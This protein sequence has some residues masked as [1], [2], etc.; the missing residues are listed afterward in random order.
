MKGIP[1]TFRKWLAGFFDGEGCV[2][3]GGQKSSCFRVRIDIAQKKP[4][5]LYHIQRI[6]GVGCVYRTEK[7]IHHLRIIGGKE[8]EIAFIK[9]ILPFSLVKQE[10]LKLA[11]QFLDL[12]GVN[13]PRIGIPKENRRRRITLAKE[14]TAFKYKDYTPRQGDKVSP[15]YICGFW[16]GDGSIHPQGKTSSYRPRISIVQKF[17]NI[18]YM[19]QKHLGFGR[20]RKP[21]CSHT[22]WGFEI[23]KKKDLQKFIR[24]VYPHILIKKK[25]LDIALQLSNLIQSN[26]IQAGPKNIAQ[27]KILG[28]CL[29]RLNS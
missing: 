1:I 15:V 9:L 6:V 7:G 12:V 10:Q 22:S 2:K 23:E 17:P 19:I 13:P 27:R 24:L 26:G 4:T 5:V 11:L 20:I 3:T 8:S 28:N 14:I 18:L 21:C 16:E 29:K 25:Q